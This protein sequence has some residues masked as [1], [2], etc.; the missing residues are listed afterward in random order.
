MGRGTLLPINSL[1]PFLHS[2]YW[3]L[4][5]LTLRILQGNIRSQEDIY[6]N[7]MSWGSIGLAIG[8][9]T[10]YLVVARSQARETLS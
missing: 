6:F 5:G 10:A 8:S 7:Q 2:G 1:R 4:L 9:L 3:Y